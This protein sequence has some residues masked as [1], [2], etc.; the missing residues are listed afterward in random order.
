[1]LPFIAALRLV[2]VP[3]NVIVMSSVPSPALNVRPV[4]PDN[5][6]VPEVAINVTVS[7]SFPASISLTVIK[8]E[9]NEKTSGV[10]GKVL[11]D[12]LPIKL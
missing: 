9:G 1:V 2:S 4:V 3:E 5:D 10:S 8:L 7:A 11:G 12:G 6:I